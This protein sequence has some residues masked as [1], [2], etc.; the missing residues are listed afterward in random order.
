MYPTRGSLCQHTIAI[1]L[2]VRPCV[3]QMH[4]IAVSVSASVTDEH[5]NTN[6]YEHSRTDQHSTHA[7][8]HILI[9]SPIPRKYHAHT[10]AHEYA[11]ETPMI[12]K[13]THT[14]TVPDAPH[15]FDSS[16]L[17]AIP[18]VCWDR[19][20]DICFTCCWFCLWCCS[21]VET[22]SLVTSIV[23]SSGHLKQPTQVE[24]ARRQESRMCNSWVVEC[25]AA[26]DK[27]VNHSSRC[28][29]TCGATG[30][31]GRYPV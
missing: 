4:M 8:T 10:D 19:C 15:F 14:V 13:T 11:H 7:R 20:F 30:R 28:Y 23:R 2:Q 24:Q 29:Q 3:L 5:S 17:L 9:T 18:T 26:S 6:A 25:G 31:K 16:F 1:A 27:R 12:L 21:R 22:Q